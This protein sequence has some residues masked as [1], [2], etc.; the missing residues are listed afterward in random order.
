VVIA[1][2][3]VG[4]IAFLMAVQP[5]LQAI[6]GRPKVGLRFGVEDMAQGRVLECEL[7]SPPITS[8]LLRRLCIRRTVAEDI[9]ALFR[10]DEVGSNK[11]IVPGLVPEITTH[12][13]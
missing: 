9:M 10:V 7:C 6:F 8:G 12:S 5:V 4:G 13:G 1:G 11:V 3:I 2:L